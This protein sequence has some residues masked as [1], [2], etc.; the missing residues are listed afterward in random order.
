MGNG[1]SN[2]PKPPPPPP[3][4]TASNG[5]LPKLKTK[6]G[7]SS[8]GQNSSSNQST[9]GKNTSQKSKV[10]S[11]KSSVRA[12][13][14]SQSIPLPPPLKLEQVSKYPVEGYDQETEDDAPAPA[15]GASYRRQNTEPK[16][17]TKI[18]RN[19]V[20]FFDEELCSDSEDE[21]NFPCC[22]QPNSPRYPPNPRR[23]REWDPSFLP[24]GTSLDSA[25][26]R[27]CRRCGT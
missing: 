12:F 10:G 20:P 25:V 19:D 14:K 3:L 21:F 16:A 27:K 2:I 17:V 26:G 23:Y 13:S 22:V 4:K 1:K 5:R 9:N 11:P 7:S 15:K 18:V 8:K 6:E 24:S